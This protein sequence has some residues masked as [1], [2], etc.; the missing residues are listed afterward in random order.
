[1]VV[2]EGIQLSIC[3][4]I[5]HKVVIGISDHGS[6]TLAKVGIVDNAVTVLVDTLVVLCI[7]ELSQAGVDHLDQRTC[8]SWECSLSLPVED[9]SHA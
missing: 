5:K 8:V 1:M 6:H 7:S 3:R 2:A 4:Q 9:W